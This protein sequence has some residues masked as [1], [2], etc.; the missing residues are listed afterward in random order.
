[1]VGGLK[2]TLSA[3]MLNLLSSIIIIKY[4]YLAIGPARHSIFKL[5]T[6]ASER[7]EEDEHLRKTFT[8][9]SMDPSSSAYQARAHRSTQLR[10]GT[11]DWAH[12]SSFRHSR[13]TDTIVSTISLNRSSQTESFPF[14][15]QEA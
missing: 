14:H 5:R 1:M 9:I 6:L 8:L 4:Q 2:P 12:Q 11:C 15:F 7:R 13:N 3:K 10:L